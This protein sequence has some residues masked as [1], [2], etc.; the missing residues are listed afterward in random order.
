MASWVE[1][2]K[3]GDMNATMPVFASCLAWLLKD[4]AWRMAFWWCFFF[5]GGL[6]LVAAT[7]IAFA[8][9]GIGIRSLDFT[10]FSGHAMRATAI[11]P[12]FLYLILNKS[13]PTVRNIGVVLGLLFGLLITVSRLVVHAHSV[14]EA[15]S[16]FVLGAIVGIGFIRIARQLANP[17]FNAWLVALSLFALTASPAAKPAPTETWVGKISVH[18]SG[19]D[20]PFTRSDWHG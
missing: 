9:W 2:T 17:T 16:G 12:V 1:I 11:M 6:A 8:G 18:L 13:T 20:R 5:L 3:L 4:R 10:G 7:K 19:R 15:I 14:S